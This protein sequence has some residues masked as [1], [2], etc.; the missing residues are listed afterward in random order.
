MLNV[1]PAKFLF[2]VAVALILPGTTSAGGVDTYVVQ[3]PEGEVKKLEFAP[4][5]KEALDAKARKQRAFTKAAEAGNAAEIE[6][7]LAEG[8]EIN[9]LDEE[10]MTALMRAAGKGRKD[11]CELLVSKGANV[12]ISQPSRVRRDAI[13][14]AVGSGDK[15][16]VDF[17]LDECARL[18]ES[19][20]R[21]VFT[22]GPADHAL[23]AAVSGNNKDM[24]HHLL[25]KGARLDVFDENGMSPLALSAA[26]T[27][28]DMVKLLLSQGAA[29][30]F[31]EGSA[32]PLMSALKAKR[33]DNALIL[34][35]NGSDIS[36]SGG[37][38]CLFK[39]VEF[40]SKRLIETLIAQ[41]AVPSATDAYGHTVLHLAEQS[42]NVEAVQLL[43]GI[44][45]IKQGISD[46]VVSATA[47][48]G[49]EEIL[50][51][52]VNEQSS[53]KRCRI[54]I[55]QQFAVMPVIEQTRNMYIIDLDT[56]AGRMHLRGET[57]NDFLQR[58]MKEWSER[59]V[60][61]PQTAKRY[62]LEDYALV[63]D[64]YFDNED[65]YVLEERNFYSRLK[66]EDR[67]YRMTADEGRKLLWKLMELIKTA[68]FSGRSV[69]EAIGMPLNQFLDT[70]MRNENDMG[71][72]F[73]AATGNL[74]AKMDKS[75]VTGFEEGLDNGEPCYYITMRLPEADLKVFLKEAFTVQ[76]ESVPGFV[77]KLVISKNDLIL[78]RVE[79]EY[80]LSA[81][82]LDMSGELKDSN[83]SCRARI[84]F[85]YPRQPLAQMVE[86]AYNG[87]VY[88][89]KWPADQ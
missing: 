10:N 4:G 72:Y 20:Q 12:L 17:L 61:N 5:E 77:Q 54:R 30:N 15:G 71:P 63:R 44:T 87:K 74:L 62:G 47:V 25:D 60:K 51:K 41:G 19:V 23:F 80:A 6:M 82:A 36:R 18:N 2:T 69:L 64:F 26:S 32:S 78:R 57:R 59:G 43:N 45:Q 48:A 13:T 14:F 27:D 88:G 73:G 33:E 85:E 49:A 7:F 65:V 83:V 50:A 24:A 68:G 76:A 38:E 28:Q 66:K 3:Y 40:G 58:A 22:N 16:L 89:Y 37:N 8:Y 31:P 46:Q 11:I 86:A 84:D 34:L 53:Q 67:Y 1:H 9:G 39:A 81:K 52:F 29:V 21:G 35:E 79:Y 56:L 75:A 55:D 70:V 42:R